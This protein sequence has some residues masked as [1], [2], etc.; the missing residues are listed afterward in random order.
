[1]ELDVHQKNCL[2]A[3]KSWTTQ[4]GTDPFSC[5]TLKKVSLEMANTSNIK[6]FDTVTETM[7]KNDLLTQ[8]NKSGKPYFVSTKQKIML[9]ESIKETKTWIDDA[10]DAV[11]LYGHH[12][13]NINWDF[14]LKKC[15]SG[16]DRDSWMNWF[17]RA[18][19]PALL[20]DRFYLDGFNRKG[21]P[22]TTNPPLCGWEGPPV[23]V[24]N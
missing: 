20:H 21:A 12:W 4:F 19:L 17:R 13:P 18:R 5:N 3:I 1:M 10:E 16:K 14:E 8:S 11:K 9:I 22:K 24:L 15:M 23:D 2:N 6:A 7:L